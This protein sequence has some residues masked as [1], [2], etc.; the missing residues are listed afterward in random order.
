MDVY[1]WPHLTMIL[2]IY[3]SLYPFLW[4]A[5]EAVR[6]RTPKLINRH[7]IRTLNFPVV[8]KEESKNIK[9]KQQCESMAFDH[10]SDSWF[11]SATPERRMFDSGLWSA[12]LTVFD[13]TTYWRSIL[14]E[15]LGLLV[16]YTL[17]KTC[18]P[19]TGADGG[20]ITEAVGSLVSSLLQSR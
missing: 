14:L 19:I 1:T 6:T 12:C 7:H 9:I 11:S 10:S 17:W 5:P 13:K 15:S 20:W 4:T 8:V 3:I 18:W 2:T 16:Q